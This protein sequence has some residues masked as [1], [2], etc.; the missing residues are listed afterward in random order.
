MIASGFARRLVRAAA[1]T[2]AAAIILLVTGPLRLTGDYVAFLVAAIAYFSIVTLS[3]SMLA[4]FCGIWPIGH[5]A[6]TAI[7][8]YLAVNL[9]GAGWPIE[10]VIPAA[11]IAAAIVG[12][13]LGLSAGRF[14]VLYF[15]L[16]TL[17]I[18]LAAF[19]IIGRWERFTGGENGIPVPPVKSLLA[20]RPIGIQDAT[21]VCV[22][23]AALVFLLIDWIC[24]GPVGRR[25]LAVKSQRIAAMAVGFVPSRENALAFSFSAAMASLSGVG[26]AIAIGYLDPEG[27]SLNVGVTMLVSTVVGGAGSLVGALIGS[28]FIIGVPEIARGASDVAPFVFGATT[29]LTLLFLRKGVAPSLIDAFMRKRG[30]RRIA[31]RPTDNRDG[32]AALVADV[33][34]ASGRAL[35]VEG[36]EVSFGGVKA[37]QGVSLSVPAGRA[38]GLMGPNG[39]GKTTML[40]VLSGF[41]IP[42]SAKAVKLGDADLLSLSPSGRIGAGFGRTFQHAEL[43]GELTIRDMLAI[44]ARQGEAARRAAGKALTEPAVVAERLIAGLGLDD[45]AESFPGELPF[46]IQKVADIARAL[47]GGAGA[48]ALDEPFSGLDSE[49][50]AKLRAILRE[51]RA[52][53]VTILIIDHAVDEIFDLAEDIYVLDFGCVI[54][55]GTPAEIRNDPKVREAYFGAPETAEDAV[56]A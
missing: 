45:V 54:A 22:L 30:A 25:W 7:G 10:A 9:G 8:A 16:L 28:A 15:G 17:A 50:A 29:V 1:I 26:L 51:L 49:E 23:L 37:L 55:H 3:V 6:F 18:S 42:K 48:I 34:P 33:L 36:V 46:G 41:V 12:Y 11:M 20:G 53:G 13:V 40:N 2:S 21:V 24:Q 38:V 35:V 32:L 27:F 39:S 5:T 47:A 44:V 56:H 43:F 31:M 52:A 19:E 14:S 4:G